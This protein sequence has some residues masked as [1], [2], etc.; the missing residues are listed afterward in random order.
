M[1]A[2]TTQP[3]SVRSSDLIRCLRL[4]RGRENVARGAWGGLKGAARAARDVRVCERR[5]RGRKGGR[6]TRLSN[7]STS[8]GDRTRGSWRG[9]GSDPRAL[10]AP[11]GFRNGRLLFLFIRTQ[12]FQFGSTLLG[13]CPRL[14][15]TRLGVGA[16]GSFTVIC[17]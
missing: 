14:R 15:L 2:D 3:I 7:R 11:S 13:R 5:K 1:I 16:S 8:S 17:A 6:L 10:A 9:L 4:H 12:L